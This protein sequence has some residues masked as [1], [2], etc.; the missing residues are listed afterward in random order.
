MA[1]FKTASIPILGVYQASDK[2]VKCASQNSDVKKE[3]DQTVKRALNLISKDVLKALSKVYNIS[4]NIDDYIFPIPRA[5]TADVPN[6]NGDRFQH[7]E[8]VRFSPR[9]RC[10]VYQTFINDPLHV[11][12]AASDPKTARGFLPD[13]HYMQDDDEKYVLTVA[14]VDTSKDPA[15]AD[16]ILSGDIDSFSMGCICDAVRCSYCG[17]V[18]HSD[19][20]LCDCLMWHKMATIGGDLVFEDCLGVEYQELSIVRDPADI[21]AT[22]QLLLQKA[23]SKDRNIDVAADF[24]LISSLVDPKDQYEVARFMKEN[25]NK[26]PEAMLRLADKIL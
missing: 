1:F 6:A 12:H 25:I 4:A 26:L 10:M 15:L 2:F 18:A 3:E 22:T 14:A 20:D 13:A 17:K 5:V 11:E 21:R 7:D 8:L 24:S 16:G 23:A 19:N 9:H